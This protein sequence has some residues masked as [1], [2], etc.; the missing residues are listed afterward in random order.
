M[1]L[2]YNNEYWLSQNENNIIKFQQPDSSHLNL[3]EDE[4]SVLMDDLAMSG[5]EAETS[6]VDGPTDF[7]GLSFGGASP[8]PIGLV[9]YLAHR[10]KNFKRKNKFKNCVKNK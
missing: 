5:D 1:A 2:R 7:S 3:M 6:A 4:N 9:G 10:H 8:Q